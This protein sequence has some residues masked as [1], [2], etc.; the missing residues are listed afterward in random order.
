MSWCMRI[1]SSVSRLLQQRA[2]FTALTLRILQLQA[3][4]LIAHYT[5]NALK[6]QSN[7][8]IGAGLVSGSVAGIETDENGNIVGFD[9]SKF[10]LGFLGGAVG[11]K[12][13]SQGFKVIKDNP[14]L[15]ESLKQELANTLAKGWE[16]TTAKYPILKALEPMK[17]MQSQKGRIAQAGHL[18]NKI[19]N[20]HL[21]QAKE[22]LKAINTSTLTKEQQE[23]L[24]V[25]LGEKSQTSIKGKDLKDIHTLEQGSRKK[26]AK[27]I[28]I[29]HYGVEKTGGLS[30]NEILD[31]SKVIKKGKINANTFSEGE[32]FI[33]YGYDLNENGVN[34]RVVVDE[35]NNS[36][37]IFDYYS[38]RNF[39]DFKGVYS[40]ELPNTQSDSTTETIKMQFKNKAL[41]KSDFI[42]YKPYERDNLVHSKS[43]ILDLEDTLRYTKEHFDNVESSLRD[44]H[45][46][47]KIAQEL[48]DK[49]GGGKYNE[50]DSAAKQELMKEAVKIR[51]NRVKQE[52]PA[53]KEKYAKE[54]QELE[55]KL[56]AFKEQN[57][58]AKEQ[59]LKTYQAEI[60]D[61]ETQEAIRKEQYIQQQEKE[62]EALR[63]KREQ[64]L[65]EYGVE[66]DED[67]V[68]DLITNGGYTHQDI[69]HIK[70]KAKEGNT[71]ARQ[72]LE[73]FDTTHSGNGY[74]GYSMSNNAIEAYNNGLMPLSKW[75]KQEA[76][77]LSDLLGVKV[78]IAQTL[79]PS[80][81]C[82]S[83]FLNLSMLKFHK[84]LCKTPNSFSPFL[85]LSMLKF[86]HYDN[87]DNYSFSPFLNL[88]M[89]K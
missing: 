1:S 57:K 21:Q 80:L 3:L 60:K 20:T 85:N 64:E 74:N 23:I 12:A 43:E 48:L 28:L 88:S 49:R 22:N 86:I 82:F 70:N 62:R 79:H 16:A 11:S 30:D 54:I 78:G 7:A 5:T 44:Y 34:Y 58:E 14:Q 4:I 87:C 72:I 19:E 39:T 33:R 31:I 8:H 38:D 50:L 75:G 41:Q 10:A 69:Q 27:K 15:K 40:P 89:L 67:Y 25:F 42:Y 63:K 24:K 68:E 59:Y 76:D 55:S 47:H 37:K 73:N 52:A 77:E 29:K 81:I 83:P 51:E 36:K 61:Y 26:G 32:D 2:G 65:K 45:Y 18:I 53:L 66:I 56:Q 17:I 6:M 13:V 35:Y 84:W 71:I 9:P 46:A